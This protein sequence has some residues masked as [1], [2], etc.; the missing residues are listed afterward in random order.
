MPTAR[1]ESL[2]SNTHRVKLKFLS[3]GAM[4]LEQEILLK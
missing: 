3:R 4:A 2:N 1:T